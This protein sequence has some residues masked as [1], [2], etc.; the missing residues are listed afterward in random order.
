MCFMVDGQ[1]DQHHLICV[2]YCSSLLNRSLASV[3]RLAVLLSVWGH[4]APVLLTIITRLQAVRRR[5]KG[6][7]D[8]LKIW[9]VCGCGM[10]A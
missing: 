7:D 2:S 8:A 9:P 3:S 1:W 6:S 5:A 4:V 10:L